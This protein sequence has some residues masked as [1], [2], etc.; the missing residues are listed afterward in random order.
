MKIPEDI[1]L[2]LIGFLKARESDI[3]EDIEDFGYLQ[4]LFKFVF[5]RY[6]KDGTPI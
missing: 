6:P 4:D 5:G 3:A 1:W 2:D